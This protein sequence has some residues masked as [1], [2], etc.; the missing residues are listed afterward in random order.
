MDE[1]KIQGERVKLSAEL[2]KKLLLE[3]SDEAFENY[4]NY[5]R[6]TKHAPI[7]R[8]TAQEIFDETNGIAPGDLERKYTAVFNVEIEGDVEIDELLENVEH[9][10]FCINTKIGNLVLQGS[11]F[12][13]NSWVLFNCEAES[14][15]LQNADFENFVV[16][17]S[18]IEE[19]SL[20]NGGLKNLHLH[21]CMNDNVIV[22]DFSIHSFMI[23]DASKLKGVLIKNNS[24][25]DDIHV[26]GNTST[27]FIE[28]Y[29]SAVNTISITGKSNVA[30]IFFKNNCQIHRI[31]IS[32]SK[33]YNIEA[34]DSKLGNVKVFSSKMDGVLIYNTDIFHSLSINNCELESNIAVKNKSD[35]RRIYVYYSSSLSLDFSRSTVHYVKINQSYFG[36]V[37]IGK[38]QIGNIIADP[39]S[40]IGDFTSEKSAIDYVQLT[41]QFSSIFLSGTNIPLIVLENCYIPR[42]DIIMG[43][44]IEAYITGGYI[45]LV[46][47]EKSSLSSNSLI[48]FSESKVY[49]LQFDE[50]SVFG[51]LFFRKIQSVNEP[52]NWWFLDIQELKGKFKDEIPHFFNGSLNAYDR[53]CKK[54]EKQFPT[55]TIRFSHSTLSKTEFTN[56]PLDD[57]RFEFNNSKI[58]DCFISGGTIPS[59]NIVIID[60]QGN[61]LNRE[62]I[63]TH[64]QKASI[65]NQFKKI[66]EAQGDT[67]R[68]AQFQAKWAEHQK[69]LLEEAFKVEKK[70]LNLWKIVR[71][72]KNE[73]A[74]DISIFWFNEKSNRHGENWFQAIKFILLVSIPA[75]VLFLTLLG[76]CFT[77]E[78]IDLSLIG[79]Y[80]EF[81]NPVRKASFIDEIQPNWAA[82]GVD[83]IS[84]ILI[85]YGIYQFIAA[86]RKHGRKK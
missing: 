58:T 47:F 5:H 32:N 18:K 57:F 41:E 24:K 36:A 7:Y 80:F 65:Y 55:S 33:V 8:L 30:G 83:F 76:R 46:S 13:V 22:D 23:Y 56:C 71:H 54:L 25:I 62:T 11:D 75:Y 37:T 51:N 16:N 39:G 61:E 40:K 3:K 69:I 81:L 70:S 21:N 38:S 14:I 72:L 59:E 63:E 66:F 20:L 53:Q 67:Y 73:K 43:S 27:D 78:S 1:K 35:I 60:D 52:F 29:Q 49:A 9:P 44:E 26:N 79:Y 74:Q 34:Y 42:F 84:R 77:S 68:A 82:V 85:A 19:I 50:F 12:S 64:R 6:E 31:N 4:K 48:S 17:N 10:L 86:F 15:K 28:C 2:F 45:N